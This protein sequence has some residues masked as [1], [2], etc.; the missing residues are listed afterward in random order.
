MGLL[1]ESWCF[2][3]GVSKTERMKD[4]IFSGKGPAIARI[5]AAGNGISGTGF[6]IHRNL[7]LTTH[8]NLPSVAA[9]E[10]A[11]IRL[12]NGV[13]ATLVPYRFFITSS[14]LDLTIVG[15]DSMDG[16]SNSQGQQP[17][18]LKTCSKGNLD[19][20]SVVYLLGYAEKEELIVGEGK[21]VIATDNLIKLST[22]GIMWSPG[23]A[24]FDVQGN[25]AFMIC[26]PMK[27][28]TSPNTKSSSNSSSSSSSWKKD[29]PMQFSIPI[30]IILDWLNQ[31]WEGSL[32]E[33]TKPKLPIIRLMST[34][35]K[36]EYCCASFTM[37]QVF[38]STEDKDAWAPSSSNVIS[39]VRDQNGSG[40]SNA[41]RTV[42]GE[43][44]NSDPH[45]THVQGIPTPEIYESPKLTS[46]PIQKKVSGQ[47]Q[48]LDINFPRK[49]AKAAIQLQSCKQLSLDSDERCVKELP[50]QSELRGEDQ[51]QVRGLAIPI[52]DADISSTGSVNGAQCEVQ[53]SSSPIEASEIHNGYS[54]EGETT[55]YS[56]ETAESRNYTSP[57]E[58]RFQQV[59]RSQSCVSYNRLGTAQRNLV[60]RRTMLEKQRSFIHG[61][62]M[63]SQGAT[64]HRSN[65]YYT[66]T[67][68][69][70]MKKRNNS[71]HSRA[72]Q[73]VVHSSPRWML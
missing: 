14:I 24:G 54:S 21:V 69:S 40:C 55:M 67:V 66:P 42:E 2:C 4:A 52:E 6:L 33:L 7:L 70:I 61:K 20:G 28:S 17:H 48:L 1:T 11:R 12:K 16:D 72:R 5:S 59:G 26:D 43:T 29:T 32:D 68:S 13:A 65:D 71:E 41:V 25:L 53:S 49:V 51:I 62:K 38:K 19:L 27:L 64:S 44:F 9:A 18:P 46:A 60:A 22:D 36:S 56:A 15:L 37:R 35:Q 50:P 8:V 39:K 23:S 45:A 30:P 34:G 3:K 47:I 63:H 31:H 73:S 57:R 58:G 10:T